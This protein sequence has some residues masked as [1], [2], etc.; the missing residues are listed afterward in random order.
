MRTQMG[1]VLETACPL[2]GAWDRQLQV[3]KIGPG[4]V[5]ETMLEWELPAP[6]HD[7]VPACSPVAGGQQLFVSESKCRELRG[8]EPGSAMRG[9]RHGAAGHRCARRQR[10]GLQETDFLTP[11]GTHGGAISCDTGA[12]GRG[13][14]GG[15]GVLQ[16]RARCP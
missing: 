9:R 2:L 7:P 1:E 16:S 3:G 4:L 15:P 6:T 12:W 8:A 14:G 13:H 11:S 10:S 5:R